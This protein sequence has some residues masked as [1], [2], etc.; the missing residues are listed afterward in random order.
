[1]SAYMHHVSGF[2]SHREEAENV[3]SQLVGQGLPRERL[4]LAAGAKRPANAPEPEGNEVLKNVLVDG[5]IGAAVGTGVGVAAEVALVAASVSLFVASP[6][7]APL[8]LLGWGAT[9]GGFVGAAVGA[10]EAANDGAGQGT[11]GTAPPRKDGDFAALV[12]D[13]IASGQVVLVADTRSAEETALAREVIEAAIGA[14]SDVR[15]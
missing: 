1:M 15:G 7:I 5:A 14:S 13:A 10:G 8:A 11:A 4:Y 12:H 6:L 2:F 9:L 3:L